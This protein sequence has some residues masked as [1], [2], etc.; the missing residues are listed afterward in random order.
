[1]AGIDNRKDIILLLLAL[2]GCSGNKFEPILGRTRMMKLLY[3]LDKEINV[4]KRLGLNSYYDFEAYHYGP[5]SKD[6]FDDIEFLRNVGLVNVVQGGPV[7]V[8]Q[9]DET[10]RLIKDE[11]LDD[12]LHVINEVMGEFVSEDQFTL[13]DKGKNFVQKILSLRP[14]QT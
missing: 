12:E 8:M 6:V 10:T 5:F 11:T 2:P 3:L 9:E 1:M 7:N 13:T 14:P 4:K